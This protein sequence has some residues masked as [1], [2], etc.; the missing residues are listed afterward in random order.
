MTAD[1]CVMPVDDCLACVRSS[2]GPPK[3]CNCNILFLASIRVRQPQ[4]QSQH[5]NEFLMRHCCLLDFTATM[6]RIYDLLHIF[7]GLDT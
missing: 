7:Y 5:F 6:T 4:A 1:H 3:D 2:D